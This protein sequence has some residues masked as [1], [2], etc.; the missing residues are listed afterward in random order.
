[1]V[2]PV[3]VW[4]RGWAGTLLLFPLWSLGSP[5][6]SPLG[7]LQ[8]SGAPSRGNNELGAQGSE[9][10]PSPALNFLSGD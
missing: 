6:P 3:R 7:S 4:E 10:C 2:G 8:D 5:A 1:M 9:F